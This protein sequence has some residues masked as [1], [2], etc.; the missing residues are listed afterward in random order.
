MRRLSFLPFVL[1]LAAT[2][3]GDAG[4]VADRSMFDRDE[5][6]AVLSMAE[7]DA[8]EDFAASL[9]DAGRNWNKLAEAVA[10]L[11]G[12]GR[13]ACIQ[14]IVDMPHLDRLEM[15][16][17][18]LIEHVTYAF[19]ARDEMPY[20]VPEEMFEPYILTYRIEEEPVDP[21]RRELYEMCAPVA[22]AEGDIVSTARALNASLARTLDEREWGFFGPRQSPLLTLKSGSGT[23]AEIAI[24]A[25]AMMKAVGIPSRQAA[26]SALGAERDGMSWVEVCDGETWLPLYPLEPNSFG[27]FG[28]IEREHAHNVT[29]V[30]S[31]S[32][33]ERLLVTERYTE[34]GTIEFTF[35]SEDVPAAD[36][37][38]FS[39]SVLNRGALV[40]LDALEAV[41]DEQGRFA[42][43]VG[44]GRYV[45]L[46]GVRDEAGN[47]FVM[48]E[49]VDVR[50]GATHRVTFDVSPRDA[51]SAY[52]RDAASA[53]GSVVTAFVLFDPD[54]EPS[55]RM[56]PLIASAVARRAPEAT[57]LCAYRDAPDV[58]DEAARKLAGA[59]ASV[60][61]LDAAAEGFLTPEGWLI[62]LAGDFGE[63]PLVQLYVKGTGDVILL[64]EGYDLNIGLSLGAAIDAQIVGLLGEQTGPGN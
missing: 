57:L 58:D 60:A 18:T 64:R 24:L 21:W 37:E 42:A 25:C 16:A 44:E 43:T 63:L 29:V 33:F 5:H 7:E 30:A 50:P 1:I 6:A 62:E 41:A 55:V 47:P 15:T 2:A 49:E 14:L 39:V 13:A 11:E 19:R 3:P 52:D 26:V 8:R 4:A 28:H 53:L 32:A 23:R 20:P 59:G 61:A 56:L 31:R 40:P 46:A 51:S 22:L 45:A 48:M 17:E 35:V 10:A 36:F 34:T 12:E 27:D 9:E 38:H 54:D